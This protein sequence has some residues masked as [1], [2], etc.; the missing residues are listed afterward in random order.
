MSESELFAGLVSAVVA[1]AAWA[2][3]YGDI[4]RVNRLAASR[5]YRIVLGLTPPACLLFLLGCLEKSSAN[6]VQESGP[7]TLLYVVLGAAWL[8]VSAHLSTFLGIS[9]RD[10]VLERR[11]RAGLIAVI[12]TLLGAI[13]CFIG[14][15]IGE[16]PGIEVV[17]ASAGAATGSWF[18]LWFF[19]ET[20]SSHAISEG[21]TVERNTGS[22]VR[23][24]GLLVANGAVLGA[25]AAGDWIPDLFF[26]DFAVSAWPA[27]VL[28][29]AA[30]VMERPLGRRSSIRLSIVIASAYLLVAIGWV[31]RQG[32]LT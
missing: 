9:A 23:L 5:G 27:A 24:A 4:F 18:A 32:V 14:G 21:I 15:N 19:L 28:T 3:W 13:L 31:L 26:H 16:G 29:V 20:L 10:D 7:Y 12:G 1:M 8:G 17:I 22:G 6:A 11:N 30:V 2:S 25:A